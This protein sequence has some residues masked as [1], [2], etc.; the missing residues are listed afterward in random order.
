DS[1][2]GRPMRTLDRFARMQPANGPG[3]G[4]DLAPTEFSVL[5]QPL[6]ASVPEPAPMEAAAEDAAQP[7]AAAPA[8]APSI[9]VARRVAIYSLVLLLFAWLGGT[10]L[11]T[12]RFLL[13]LWSARYLLRH[14]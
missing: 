11:M 3:L 9:P 6:A 14:S 10:L 1:S 2:T 7:I 13:G 5:E 12:L 4:D 8:P